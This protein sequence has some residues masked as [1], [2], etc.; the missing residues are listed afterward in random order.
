MHVSQYTRRRLLNTNANM[1]KT[2]NAQY[3]FCFVFRFLVT[4][5]NQFLIMLGRC[6]LYTSVYLQ[7]EPTCL[8]I[9][10]V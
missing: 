1:L 5:I 4:P 2:V 3:Y 7:D 8:R 6:A 9:E 10:P